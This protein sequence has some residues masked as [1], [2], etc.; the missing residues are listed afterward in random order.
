MKRIVAALPENLGFPLSTGHYTT[1][2]SSNS[3][4]SD[5]LFWPLWP[6]GIH[7]RRQILNT[8]KRAE[9]AFLG[10]KALT[11][12]PQGKTAV[13]S[14]STHI[15]AGRT[16]L[17]TPVIPALRRQKQGIPGASWLAKLANL[18]SSR[19]KWENLPQ[20]IRWRV[21]N[22]NLWPPIAHTY[23]QMGMRTQLWR[24]VESDQSSQA[25]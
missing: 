22:V 6:P 15:S 25:S 8:L 19:L 18:A 1:L 12:Q 13:Q 3:K 17:P 24:Q 2:C 5:V 7:T 21:A 16:K 11:I 10:G 20:Y 4:W 9:E 14:P 23:V